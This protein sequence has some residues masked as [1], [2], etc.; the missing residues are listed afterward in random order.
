MR[1]RIKKLHTDDRSV[2]VR[3]IDYV[4][5][6]QAENVTLEIA[7]RHV[8]D[9]LGLNPNQSNG[10]IAHRFASLLETKYA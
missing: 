5:L 4:R 6:H 10:R 2:M 3:F 7:A 1:K 8:C 9:Y